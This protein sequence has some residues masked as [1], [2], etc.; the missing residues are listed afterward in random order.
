MKRVLQSLFTLTFVVAFAG[1]ATA[2]QETQCCIY[3]QMGGQLTFDSCTQPATPIICAQQAFAIF[4]VNGLGLFQS[5]PGINCGNPT[6]QVNINLPVELT[7]FEATVVS[8]TEIMLHW[9]TATEINN[10]GFHVEHEVGSG[11][12]ADLG[13]VEGAG[14][15]AEP[16]SYRFVTDDLGAGTHVF[17]LKQIDFDGAF[18]YSEIVEAT[19]ELPEQF[20][21]EPAYPNPFNPATTIRFGTTVETE[22]TVALF[23][24]SGKLVRTLYEGTPDP[25][26]MNSLT[27]DGLEFIFQNTPGS[28][29]YLVK[30][31]A[32]DFQTSQTIVL[33][34]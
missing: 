22:V 32:A 26:S 5:G 29:N 4:G 23:D 2:Q 33:L 10:A 28:G 15:T 21:L 6:C 25:G 20:V 34:K 18:E 30:L 13:F 14:T 12:F 11:E 19:L 17:R 27:I 1:M 9:E 24:A 3:E 16:Q 8:T 7:S 31:L